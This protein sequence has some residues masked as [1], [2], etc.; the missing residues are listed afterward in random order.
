MQS[1][2]ILT[3]WLLHQSTNQQKKKKEEERNSGFATG[4]L[5]V[6]YCDFYDNYF[7]S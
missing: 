7:D 5:H 3:K 2:G 1:R 4:E 6:Q